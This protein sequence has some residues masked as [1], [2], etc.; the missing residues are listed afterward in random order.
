MLFTICSIVYAYKMTSHILIIQQLIAVTKRVLCKTVTKNSID[1]HAV[2]RCVLD[3][4]E[5]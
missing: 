3:N 1:D 4:N 2:Q 5:S